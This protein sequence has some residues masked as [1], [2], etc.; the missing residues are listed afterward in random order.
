MPSM[1]MCVC[2]S[3][4]ARSSRW[5]IPST[6]CSAHPR[7]RLR[8]IGNGR[9]RESVLRYDLA[10]RVGGS[11]GGGSASQV[12]VAVAQHYLPFGR[13]SGR[14]WGAQQ[15]APGQWR[16]S[17]RPYAYG[18]ATGLS[19]INGT[20]AFKRCRWRSYGCSDCGTGVGPTKWTHTS[21]HRHW[22]W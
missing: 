6:I 11:G 2:I 12:T 3:K 10:G 7:L 4:A 18:L 8:R 15:H 16:H 5:L 14:G 21:A 17:G 20:G 19:A 1:C 9:A 22:R 13:G